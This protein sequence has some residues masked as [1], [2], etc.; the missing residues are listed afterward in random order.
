MTANRR[1]DGDEFEHRLLLYLTSFT[2]ETFL[3]VKKIKNGI[4][5]C[6]T[7]KNTWILKE[8]PTKE[9]IENQI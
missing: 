7:A 1:S 6:K 4:W 8:F 3:Y 2:G 9:K 5:V